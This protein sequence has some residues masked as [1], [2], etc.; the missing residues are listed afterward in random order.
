M[1]SLCNGK[2]SM[3]AHVRTV[4]MPKTWLK[5]GEMFHC[6]PWGHGMDGVIRCLWMG[7]W[8]VLCGYRGVDGCI[9]TT[10]RMKGVS[11][12]IFSFDAMR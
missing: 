3:W 10:P 4:Y 12:T 7:L 5:L 6:D 1:N 2:G 9:Q 8:S 11:S